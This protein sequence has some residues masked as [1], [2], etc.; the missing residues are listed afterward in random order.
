MVTL[1][2]TV[3]TDE[4]VSK[5][6]REAFERAA[7][8]TLLIRGVEMLPPHGQHRLVQLSQ[9]SPW[10]SL[11]EPIA[12]E[13]ETRLI[14]TTRRD[15]R[16]QVEAGRFREDLYYLLSALSIVVPPLRDR[17]EDIPLLAEHILRRA[18]VQADPAGATT[19]APSL[20]PGALDLLVNYD[21]PGNIRELEQVVHR[22]AVA[23]R[24][25]RIEAE[26]IQF[27]QT[28]ATTS[29][30]AAAGS[31][32]PAAVSL[33]ETIANIERKLIESALQRASGNQARAAQFLGIPRTTL[34]DKMAKYGMTGSSGREGIA[35]S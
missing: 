21:W 13:H 32:L 33:T 4:D 6:L 20:S 27:P 10:D 7:G 1:D 22:A 14:C 8:S 23:A 9:C 35:S 16:A 19:Q 2:A 28:P 5:M 24:S 31:D 15:L 34:R 26:H 11:S 18:G 30:W 12:S 17:R 25:N 29:S 3:G